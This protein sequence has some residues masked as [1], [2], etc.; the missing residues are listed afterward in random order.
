VRLHPKGYLVAVSG[1]IAGVEILPTTPVL[2]LA[3]ESKAPVARALIGAGDSALINP[4]CVAPIRDANLFLVLDGQRIV[5]MDD[6][7]ALVNFFRGGQA[8]SQVYTPSPKWIDVDT[9]GLLYIMGPQWGLNAINLAT[10]SF[11]FSTNL[12]PVN[13]F[14]VDYWRSIYTTESQAAG[15]INDVSS[16]PQIRVWRPVKY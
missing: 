12:G 7:G 11:Y 2:T 14:A 1:D 6:E 15:I 13:Q 8:Y 5:C 9:Q 16:V 3:Q 10:G 4:T